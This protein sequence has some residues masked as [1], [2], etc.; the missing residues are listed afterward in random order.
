[1]F[2]DHI[3]IKAIESREISFYEVSGFLQSRC[4]HAFLFLQEPFHLLRNL[5]AA[6]Q[7][8]HI[9]TKLC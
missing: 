7:V 2:H 9:L 1:M 5:E 8:V 4:L 6:M 3:K